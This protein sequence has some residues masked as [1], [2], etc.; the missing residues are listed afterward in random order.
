[1]DTYTQSVSGAVVGP[2]KSPKRQLRTIVEKRQI[3]EET[4]VEGAPKHRCRVEELR[5]RGDTN[6]NPARSLFVSQCFKRVQLRCLSRRIV[7]KKYPDTRRKQ[8]GEQ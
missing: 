6:G 8:A 1:M 2:A 7:T 5:K 4:M 3:V